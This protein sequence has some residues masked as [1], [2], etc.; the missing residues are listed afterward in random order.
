MNIAQTFLTD[1][2]KPIKPV[3]Q[4]L[5]SAGG[6]PY[7]AG[8]A[9]RDLILNLPLKDIDIEVHGLSLEKLQSVLERIAPVKLVGK[10]FGV[11]RFYGKDIDF[12]IPRTDSKGRKPT[13]SFDPSMTIEMACKRR[14]IT[15]NAM[16]LDLEQIMNNWD[17][18]TT[19][20]SLNPL[21]DFVVHDPYGGIDDITAKRIR[22]IDPHLFV[23][24]PLRFYRVMHFMS[25]FSMTPDN[26]LDQLCAT[27]SL[28]DPE[29]KTP[30]SRERIYEEIRKM[31]LRSQRPS[32]GFRWLEKIGRLEE[33]FPELHALIATPQRADYHPEGNA[34]EHSM[35]ALDAAA[36]LPYGDTLAAREARVTDDNEKFLIMTAALCHDLGKAVATDCNLHTH[37]HDL[38]GVPITKTFLKRF[39]LSPDLIATVEKLVRHHLMPWLLM[40]QNSTPRAYK[41]LASA[42]APETTLY[43]LALVALCDRRGRNGEGPTPLTHYGPEF[44]QFIEKT[45][46][47]TITHQPEK[48]LL[49]GRDIAHL[50]EGGPL[51]GQ[52]LHHAY[53][54]QIEE[55]IK[56]PSVL[57]EAVASF[58][59]KLR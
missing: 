28:A 34:F 19:A 15:M 5:I 9:V 30:L 1:W 7:L 11:L 48:P 56:E 46:S 26:A 27:M 24:D 22:A 36:V 25:R 58:L 31:F 41:R 2:I 29:S 59:K 35:Q 52:A 39:I 21:T 53:A 42:V 33:L 40:A 38:A 54:L 18:L 51:M 3:L 14:D 10:Q 44:A 57:L 50:V 17:R 16:A 43:Q 32:L 45:D 47:L 8:G 23:E 20:A 4:A 55:N 37:G 6:K 13:V 49:H 12:S